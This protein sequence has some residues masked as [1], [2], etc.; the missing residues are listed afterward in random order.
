MLYVDI[1]DNQ[2][3]KTG[4]LPGKLNLC[5]GARGMLIANIN[6]S[7]HPINGSTGKME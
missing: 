4:N 6:A 3:N 7:D 2:I 5:L 1:S